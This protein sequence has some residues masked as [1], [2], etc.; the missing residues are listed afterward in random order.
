[1]MQ[2]M[3]IMEMIRKSEGGMKEHYI[4]LIKGLLQAG[5]HVTALCDFSEEIMAELDRAGAQTIRFRFPGTI[6]PLTD[7]V[8]AAE[9]YSIIRKT[10]PDIV[11]CHGFKAGLIGRL[12]GLAA[13]RHLVYTAHNFV[14]YGRGKRSSFLIRSFE[15]WIGSKTDAVICVSQA[16]KDNMIQGMGLCPDKLHVV[17]NSRPAWVV[18]GD[19]R[20]VRNQYGI[21]EQT[22]LIGT[23]ARLIPSKGIHLLIEAA[24]GIL[25]RHPEALFLIAGSGPEEARLKHEAERLKIADRVIF[26]GQVSNMQDYYSAFDIFILPTLSEGLGITVLEAMSFGLPVIAAAVGG[27]PELISHGGNGLLMEPGKVRQIEDTL[28]FCLDH[29]QIAREY[30]NQAKKFVQNGFTPEEMTARTISIFQSVLE[31]SHLTK[32]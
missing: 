21:G 3:K 24:P 13:G 5:H 10:K 1:M 20:K 32:S 27:I 29:P 22:V 15:K 12:P 30:G 14:L 26:T 6:S 4:T 25:A 7:I 16:L 17:Y 2:Q 31:Q 18:S 11:H 23:A 28:H 9:L 8:R 19:R